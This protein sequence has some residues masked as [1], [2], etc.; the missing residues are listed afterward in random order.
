[1]HMQDERE[2][3]SPVRLALRGWQQR[4]QA[5]ID[6]ARDSDD[7]VARLPVLDQLAHELVSDL[8]RAM[9]GI[10]DAARP[11]AASPSGTA[12]LRTALGKAHARLHGIE[13][14]HRAP[15]V[16]ALRTARDVFAAAARRID[17]A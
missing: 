10:D 7:L 17:D 13:L 6:I 9:G 16:T 15:S 3:V 4:V 1:M 5:V 8:G 11:P 14:W 12:T 2:T